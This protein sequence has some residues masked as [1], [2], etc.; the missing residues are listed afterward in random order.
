MWAPTIAS[1]T[2]PRRTTQRSQPSF[3]RRSILRANT[4]LFP[5]STDRPIR[6][7]TTLR[8]RATGHGRLTTMRIGLISD[9]HVPEAGTELWPQLWERIS[10]AD[11][12]LHGG[13]IHDIALIDKLEAVVPIYVARGNGDDG[14]GGRPVQPED[15]RLREAWTLEFE[16]F[17]F[18]LT[19]DM[20]LPEWPPYR[21]VESM[22]DHYFGGPRH[23][24]VHGDTHVASIET[25]RGVLLINPGSPMYPRNLDTR[26]GTLGFIE[27]NNGRLHAWLEQLDEH[28]SH[29]VREQ[30]KYVY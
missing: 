6:T 2:T 30:P 13:D 24:V 16:G 23:V 8:Y 9:T 1:A 21:T 28:G 17:T 26:L 27:I 18:G 20:A 29:V 15:P 5:P 14:S 10:T 19:H 12:L 22:M 7:K 11:V 25:I 4:P 3:A